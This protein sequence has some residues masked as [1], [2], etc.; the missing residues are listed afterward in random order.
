MRAASLVLGASLFA[1]A[2]CGGAT[3]DREAGSTEMGDFGNAT[4]NNTMIHN[5]D[6]QYTQ[7]LANRFA[8]EV[9]DTVTFAFNSAV[10]DDA[11]RRTL[12]EQANWIRQFPEVRFRVYGHT[13]LVGSAGY[14]KALGLRRAQAVVA[15]F[16]SQGISRSRLEAIASYGKTRPVVQT[17]SPEERNR[18]TVT[19]VSGFVGRHPTLL[20]GKY[21]RVIMREYLDLARRP[22]PANVVIETQAAPSGG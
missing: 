12:Y 1:L 17:A 14:N 11:A 7:V 15:Y 2:A 9:P 6:L 4:M 20:N 21:A 22:H 5:G 18:R 3:F 10:L 8:T 16:S 13:D 19:E